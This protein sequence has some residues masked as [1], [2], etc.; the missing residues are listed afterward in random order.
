MEELVTKGDICDAMKLRG[1]IVVHAPAKSTHRRT[2][3]HTTKCHI[4]GMWADLWC[5]EKD[6]KPS[7]N[8]QRY[9]YDSGPAVG[10]MVEGAV[11][12]TGNDK[13]RACRRCLK[14]TG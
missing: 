11:R 10:D 9:I 1:F 14:N 2:I 6:G 4:M 12:V 5:R 13:A 8:R 3:V 7:S